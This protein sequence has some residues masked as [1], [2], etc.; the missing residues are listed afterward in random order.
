MLRAPITHPD[1]LHALARAGHGSLVLVADAHFAASTA[2]SQ[3]AVVVHLA[4]APGAPLVPDVASLISATIQLEAVTTM[5]APDEELGRVARQ[6]VAAAGSPVHDSVSRE[7][8]KALTRSEDMALCIVTG[9]TRRF[10]NALLRV[11]VTT[12]THPPHG[13][14]M[15]DT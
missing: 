10:A 1:V 5:T 2:V 6:A 4:L 14:G 7:E 12:P 3:K 9:D 8:F 15:I 13:S 11:G